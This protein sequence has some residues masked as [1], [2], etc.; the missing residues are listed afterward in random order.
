MLI[1]CVVDENIAV[2]FAQSKADIAVVG[3]D[4]ADELIVI[5]IA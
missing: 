3:E 1:A 5:R 4:V 2:G